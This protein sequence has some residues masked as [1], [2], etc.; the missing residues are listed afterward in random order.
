[1]KLLPLYFF[2]LYQIQVFLNHK[3]KSL[4]KENTM[5]SNSIFDNGGRI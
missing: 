3:N 1:M 4:K 5:E 2:A